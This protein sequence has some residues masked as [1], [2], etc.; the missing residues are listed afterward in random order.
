MIVF[1]TFVNW[2]D[3]EKSF[4]IWIMNSFTAEQV[5]QSVAADLRQKGISHARAASL[6]GMKHRQSFTNLLWKK[7]Y[8][9]IGQSEKLERVFGYNRDFLMSGQGELIDPTI[10][11][12]TASEESGSK[13]R[14]LYDF[15]KMCFVGVLEQPIQSKEKEKTILR[16][17]DDL[18]QFY[19]DNKV[20]STET[21]VDT[22]VQ[23]N[24]LC[25]NRPN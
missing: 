11:D 13:Y 20:L 7:D 14:L 23:L 22:I 19:F 9:S 5:K 25:C 12:S 1:I 21:Y 10:K 3:T 4:N 16:L 17:L 24:T 8:F 18:E 15:L 6:L 2:I